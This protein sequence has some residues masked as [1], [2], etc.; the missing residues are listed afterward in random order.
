MKYFD[1]K[2]SRIFVR[3]GV[4]V[5]MVLLFLAGVELIWPQSFSWI[6]QGA[7]YSVKPFTARIWQSKKD[8]KN[9][10]ILFQENIALKKTLETVVYDFVDYQKL[11]KEN[12]QLKS[13]LEFFEKNDFVYESAKIIGEK[14]V[15]DLNFIIID[16]GTSDGVESGLP[17]IVGNGMLLGI[18]SHADSNI[19]YVIPIEKN[20][21]ALSARILGKDGTV[22]GVV[23]NNSGVATHLRLIPKSLELKSGD[24]IVTSGFDKQIPYGLVIGNIERT[25]NEVN[26]FFQS[27]VVNFLINYY[28]YSVV[29]VVKL[30]SNSNEN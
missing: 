8:Q 10:D 4:V 12:I 24:L 11:K 30:K 13:A 23:E 6:R 29:H 19:S 5:L 21:G 2:N 25:E 14:V 15:Q 26:S 22:H 18:I 17:V 3:S 27:A 28:D 16:I 1:K 20:I 7:V 9:I